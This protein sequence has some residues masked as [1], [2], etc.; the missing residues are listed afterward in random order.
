LEVGKKTKGMYVKINEKEIT[1]LRKN[2]ILAMLEMYQDR[3]AVPQD[4]KDL[5]EAYRNAIQIGG[6]RGHREPRRKLAHKLE[7][8]YGWKINYEEL[9]Q[10]FI[11][12]YDLGI[13]F[14][15]KYSYIYKPKNR[16]QDAKVPCFTPNAIQYMIENA[17]KN[18]NFV[19]ADRALVKQNLP[20]LIRDF[21][22]VNTRKQQQE[23]LDTRKIQVED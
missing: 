15:F 8:D 17:G 21:E 11:D 19:W 16:T 2:I 12:L 5:D 22:K 20:L 1:G 13:V 14:M 3:D 18:A 10:A 4:K 7:Q 23:I 6:T 9:Y